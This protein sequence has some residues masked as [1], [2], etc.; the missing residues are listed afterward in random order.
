MTEQVVIIIDVRFTYSLTYFLLAVAVGG[1]IGKYG[2]L[3][4]HSWLLVSTII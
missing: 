2:R 1:I 4:E 3:S